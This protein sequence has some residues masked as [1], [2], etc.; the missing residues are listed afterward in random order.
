M[1]A[2]LVAIRAAWSSTHLPVSAQWMQGL[3]KQGVS[4]TIYAVDNTHTQ[5]IIFLD[6]RSKRVQVQFYHIWDNTSFFLE[7]QAVSVG[8]G[9]KSKYCLRGPGPR[10]WATVC[11]ILVYEKWCIISNIKLDLYPSPSQGQIWCLKDT[12]SIPFAWYCCVTLLDRNKSKK[13]NTRTENSYQFQ[14]CIIFK[15]VLLDY[16]PCSIQRKCF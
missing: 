4:I 12:H 11:H 7:F 15:A 10:I 13:F 5:W 14:M 3:A 16:K 8:D 6:L 9:C 2:V 1:C